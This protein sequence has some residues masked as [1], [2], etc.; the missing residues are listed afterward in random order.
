MRI[1]FSAACDAFFFV[2]L[3]AWLALSGLAFVYIQDIDIQ[4]IAAINF[5]YL[6]A[7]IVSAVWGLIR[8]NKQHNQDLRNIRTEISEY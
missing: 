3:L 6:A 4:S 8:Q 5:I 7:I 2:V 1:I